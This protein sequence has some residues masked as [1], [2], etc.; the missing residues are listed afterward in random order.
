MCKFKSE[1]WL[2]KIYLK[3]NSYLAITVCVYFDF[4]NPVATQ[5]KRFLGLYNLSKAIL[6]W[7][8]QNKENFMLKLQHLWYSV[9]K[10]DIQI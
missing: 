8:Q 7:I 5:I 1:H 2:L 6:I 4:L 9:W 3:P 10:E